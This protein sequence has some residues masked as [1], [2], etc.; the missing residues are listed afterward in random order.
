MAVR[1][2]V[3]ASTRRAKLGHGKAFAEQA[4]EEGYTE[5]TSAEFDQ[6]RC[7]TRVVFR[8]MVLA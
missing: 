1:Y 4:L 8:A 3:N 7:Q 2:F 6:F 5:V